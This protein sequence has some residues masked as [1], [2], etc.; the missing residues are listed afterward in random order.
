M[1]TPLNLMV[2]PWYLGRPVGTVVLRAVEHGLFAHADA[3]SAHLWQVIT[4]AA[5]AA[6]GRTA[7]R[8]DTSWE[9]LRAGQMGTLVFTAGACGVSALTACAAFVL[10]LLVGRFAAF[11]LSGTI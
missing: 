6:D 3:A 8:E 4:A 11:K 1:T 5:A 7:G 9:D 2:H 10:E